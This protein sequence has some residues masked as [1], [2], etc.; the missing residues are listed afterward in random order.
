MHAKLR[1]EIVTIVSQEPAEK[2]GEKSAEKRKKPPQGYDSMYAIVFISHKNIYGD[3]QKNNT[4][5]EVDH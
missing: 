1:L 2:G 5:W 3:G 4:N